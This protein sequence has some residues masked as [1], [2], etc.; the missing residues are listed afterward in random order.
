MSLERALDLIESRASPYRFVAAQA[1]QAVHHLPALWADLAVVLRCGAGLSLVLEPGCRQADPAPGLRSLRRLHALRAHRPPAPWALRE[2]RAGSH[3]RAVGHGS[4][5]VRTLFTQAGAYPCALSG[6][7]LRDVMRSE[8][9][10]APVSCSSFP[11]PKP[12]ASNR[13]PLKQ[14]DPNQLTVVLEP[15]EDEAITTARVV[16]SPTVQ[17]AITLEEYSKPC[18]DL[19]VGDL[20]DAL[21]E[22]TRASSNGDLQRAETMLTAQAHTLDAIFNKLA[23]RAIDAERMDHLDRFLKLAL[24]AQ[25]QCRATW[26]ALAALK[27]PPTLGYVQQANIAQGHQQVNNAA[28]VP[29]TDQCGESDAAKQTIGDE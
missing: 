17:A 20:I 23:R 25:A 26:E 5:R 18:G 15:G 19:D 6:G 28:A 22:Q 8:K 1:A 3:R 10:R 13:K 29:A 24:R 7:G 14:R 9:T 27:R 16:L 4:T 2:R 11:R 21:S 12:M